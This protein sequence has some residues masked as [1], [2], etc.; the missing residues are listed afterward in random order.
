[1]HV[2]ILLSSLWKRGTWS[3]EIQAF[4]IQTNLRKS[5]NFSIRDGNEDWYNQDCANG[6]EWGILNEQLSDFYLYICQA[7]REN[8]SGNK[9][10]ISS[11]NHPAPYN[12][13]SDC[14]YKIEVPSGMRVKIRFQKFVTESAERSQSGMLDKEMCI[15]MS[16]CAWLEVN[17]PKVTID[18]FGTTPPHLPFAFIVQEDAMTTWK[19][20]TD[21]QGVIHHWEDSVEHF[22]HLLSFP[23]VTS[24]WWDLYLTTQRTSVDSNSH[25]QQKVQ[26]MLGGIWLDLALDGFQSRDKAAMLLHKTIANDG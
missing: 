7:C 13:N 21:P 23:Q 9:G 11:P 5:V 14:M 6:L 22:A 20:M 12:S 1:M 25:I 17:L 8:Y 18:G 3:Y 19:H 26:S 2:Q 24:C 15:I 16:Y 4:V 10:K